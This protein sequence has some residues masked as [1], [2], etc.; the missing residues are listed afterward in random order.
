MLAL[1]YFFLFLNRVFTFFTIVLIVTLE[2]VVVGCL[3]VAVAA[4]AADVEL[5]S[6]LLP[7]LMRGSSGIFFDFLCVE[8][9][10]CEV[11]V[12]TVGTLATNPSDLNFVCD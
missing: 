11:V 3:S 2:F 6:L 4:V 7:I 10:L 12:V 8:F 1:I 5:S 9:V